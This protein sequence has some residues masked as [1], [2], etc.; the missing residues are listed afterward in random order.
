MIVDG[1]EQN[2]QGI[3]CPMCGWRGTY[4]TDG[5]PSTGLTND[6]RRNNY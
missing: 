6:H 1:H 4:V 5:R 3:A 2:K